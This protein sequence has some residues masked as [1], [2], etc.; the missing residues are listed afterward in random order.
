MWARRA[1]TF[2]GTNNEPLI[3][4]RRNSIRTGKVFRYLSEL[5]GL[6]GAAMQALWLKSIVDIASTGISPGDWRQQLR[7]LSVIPAKAGIHLACRFAIAFWIPA[8]AGMTG[9]YF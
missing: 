7:W 1:L 8:F 3:R 4:S 9:F 5:K 2:L 6:S